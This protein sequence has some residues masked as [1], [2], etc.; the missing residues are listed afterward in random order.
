M[1]KIFLL[2]FFFLP[3]VL[4]VKAEGVQDRP[5]CI[6]LKNGKVDII[7]RDIIKQQTSD[8][9]SLRVSLQNDTVLTYAMNEVDS[10]GGLPTRFPH[11]TMFKFNNKYN[12]NVFVDVFATIGQNEVTATVGAIGKSLTPSFQLDSPNAIALVNDV[13]QTSKVS[14]HRFDKP[15]VYTLANGNYRKLRYV[16]V[17]DEIW[18]EG[19]PGIVETEEIALQPYMLSTNAPSNYGENVDNLVDKNKNTIFHSTWGSG[20]YEKLPLDV[21]PYIEVSLEEAISKFVFKYTTSPAH[22]NRYPTEFVIQ[23]SHDQKVWND[24]ATVNVDNGMPTAGLNA[25]F[26]SPVISLKE[27]YKYLRFKM[28]SSSYKNYLVLAEFSLHKVVAEMGGTSP[29]LISPEKYAYRWMPFGKDIPVKVEWLTDKATNVPRLD[30]NVKGKQMIEDKMTY[31]DA[32]IVIDGAGVFPDMRDSMRIRGRG[33]SSWAGT[34]KSPYRLKFDHSVKPFGLT[35]GKNWV[36]LANRQN[37][38]MLTNA[39]G[40]KVSNMAKTAGANQIVPVELYINGEYRGNYNFTQHVGLHNNSVDIVETNAALLELDLYYDEQFKFL[41]ATYGVRTNVK[42]PDLSSS[43]TTPSPLTFNMIKNDFNHFTQKAAEGTDE[44][45]QLMNIPMFA[46]YMLVNELIFNAELKHPKSCFLYK[47]DLLALHSQYVFGPTWDFDWAYGYEF[48]HNYCHTTP[49]INFFDTLNG[50]GGNLFKALFFNSEIV[51]RA[52]YKEWK[53]FMENSMQEVLD[54][55][56]DYYQYVRPSLLHN[57]Q[58]WGDGNNYENNAATFKNWLKERAEFIYKNLPTYNLDEELPITV[59]DVNLDGAITLADAICVQNFVLNLPNET[60][61][62]TQADANQNGNI[63]M[64]DAVWIVALALKAEAN[65]MHHMQLPAA[66]ATWQAADFTATLGSESFMPLTL[67]TGNDEYTATQFDL[68]LPEGVTLTDVTLPANWNSYQAEFEATGNQQYRVVVYG[69]AGDYLPK[70][71]AT[72]QLHLTPEQMLA[73]DERIV[74]LSRATLVNRGGEDERLGCMSARF[75]M[76]ATGIHQDAAAQQAVNGGKALYVESLTAG[77]VNIYT[78]DGRLV[79]VCKVEAGKNVISLPAG[80]YIVNQKK[81][82][83]NH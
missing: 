18:S 29:E 41:D 53:K 9:Q 55:I 74:S 11:F 13:P 12:H 47:E 8:T 66:Q 1:K 56:D 48:T 3:L 23:A 30:I 35:K 49:D 2:L 39:I 51:Q 40:M 36:L 24:M 65:E 80:V 82:V 5:L 57:A 54:Y 81:V 44:Y 10:L 58:R 4:T 7:P 75:D 79:K 68:T 69:S 61:D 6:Y 77:N 50:N 32:E 83:I 63:N 52:Y 42:S 16:K 46:R 22:N 33:N 26:A 38:S 60:F 76:D 17:Q 19:I 45:T 64:T 67:K 72:L 43:A 14:R 78:V 25:D 20:P 15:V 62:M 27:K 28:T 34:G 71:T 37:G 21:A 31:L 59:G 73:G 70:G